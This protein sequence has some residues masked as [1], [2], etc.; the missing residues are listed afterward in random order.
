MGVQDN[1]QPSSWHRHFMPVFFQLPNYNFKAKLFSCQLSP[2][3]TK[4]DSSFTFKFVFL[5]WLGIFQSVSCK[6]SST[7]TLIYAISP[8][9]E[10]IYGI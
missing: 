3:E 1:F 6:M 8:I 7:L 4:T 5:K 2:I 10:I 9:L